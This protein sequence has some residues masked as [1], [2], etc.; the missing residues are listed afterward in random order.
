MYSPDSAMASSTV[1][2]RVALMVPSTNT[3][4]EPDLFRELDGVAT[5]HTAR[6][7]LPDPVTTAGE[8][9]LLDEFAVPAAQ[10]LSGIEPSVAVFGC[11]SAGP[12]RG[13]AGELRL[14]EEL[15]EIMGAPV[16]GVLT[17]AVE[18]LRRRGAARISILT[19]YTEELNL[20]IERTL[21]GDFEVLNIFGMGIA[22][23][24][25]IGRCPS[26]SV[27]EAADRAV[28]EGSDAVFVSCTNLSALEAR[29]AI[30]AKFGIPTVT[31]NSAVIEAVRRELDASS[32]PGAATA[33][34]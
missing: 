14:R 22:N 29:A 32:E 27:V 10:D 12:L 5:V 24:R 19:P 26:E 3:T 17:A 34:A 30:E 18:A 9:R 28:A 20:A 23:N 31:A 16:V 6:M 15:A 33:R 1:P 13:A 25:D 8:L 2:A 11:T 21:A 4:M 7:Y